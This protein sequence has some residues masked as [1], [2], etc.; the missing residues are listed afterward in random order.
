MNIVFFGT[1]E[2]SATVL[3]GLIDNNY[4]VVAVVSQP[5]KVNAR[6]NKIVFSSIKK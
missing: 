2:F 5:D 3:K 1:G 6:N 4:N